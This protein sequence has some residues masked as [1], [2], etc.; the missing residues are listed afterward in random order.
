M[1]STFISLGNE[2]TVR[3]MLVYSLV[4]HL[5]RLVA[6]KG[7]TAFNRRRI[8]Q[9][10]NFKRFVF[11]H[12]AFRVRVTYAATDNFAAVKL[13]IYVMLYLCHV[14]YLRSVIK[15][16]GEC[17]NKKIY[18]SKRHIAINPPQNTSPRFE[19]TYTIVLATF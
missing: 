3:E 1:L 10:K 8:L 19:H 12:V 14:M 4:N 7:F 13:P 9:L 6:R 5:T 15:T 17:L 2:N 11:K 16:Y 18:C